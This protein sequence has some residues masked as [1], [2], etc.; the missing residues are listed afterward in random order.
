MG[1][2]EDEEKARKQMRDISVRRDGCVDLAAI[3]QSRL[4]GYEIDA[5]EWK[6]WSIVVVGGQ[7]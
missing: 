3:T 1:W 4:D 6:F 2:D 7:M 5:S